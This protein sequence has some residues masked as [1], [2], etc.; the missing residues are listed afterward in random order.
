[1]VYAITAT[2]SV[3][4]ASVAIS[5]TGGTPGETVYVFRRDETGIAPLR[6]SAEGV[7]WPGSDPLTLT[8]H[9]AYQAGT[10]DY[11]L[12]DPDGAILATDLAVTIP[13]WGTWLKDPAYPARNVRVYMGRIGPLLLPARREIVPIED[14]P[15]DVVV[16][17]RRPSTQSE[18][19]V[20]VLDE[21][22]ATDLLEILATG[23]TIM[24]DADPAWNLGLRYVSV[25]PVTVVR[26]ALVEDD[27]IGFTDAART[28]LLS[29]L[30]AVE[31]PSGA[32]SVSAGWTYAAVAGLYA[33]YNAIPLA[34][35][36]N[37]VFAT[38]VPDA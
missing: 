19:E 4:T 9:E 30:V 33:T 26:P 18:V 24:L 27:Q 17:Q 14:S 22:A 28:F 5:A 36:T 12:T 35:T 8:D 7:E 2:P 34:F 29:E 1:M 6:D 37:T 32:S 11:I 16:T 38:G 15:L 21:Q 23:E 25:G 20:S 13:A 10:T 3:A 31:A